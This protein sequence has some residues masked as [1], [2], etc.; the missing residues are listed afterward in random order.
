MTFYDVGK[1]AMEMR[2]CVVLLVV[3][4]GCYREF[5]AECELWEVD[6]CECRIEI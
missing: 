6:P 2:S 1:G 5:D 3:S 4:L